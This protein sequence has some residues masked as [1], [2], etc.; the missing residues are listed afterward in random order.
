MLMVDRREQN[1]Q[2]AEELRQQKPVLWPKIRCEMCGRTIAK[3]ILVKGDQPLA[4][5]C[6]S[7][8]C[9]HVNVF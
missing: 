1:Q 7:K 5:Q 9:K 4:I 2:Q 3:G 6:W 8:D